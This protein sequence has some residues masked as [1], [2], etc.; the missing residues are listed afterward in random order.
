MRVHILNTRIKKHNIQLI[1]IRCLVW[2]K[3]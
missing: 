1:F 3:Q 2:K